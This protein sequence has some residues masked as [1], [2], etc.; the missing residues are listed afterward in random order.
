MEA[1]FRRI[2]DSPGKRARRLDGRCENYTLG[3]CGWERGGPVC[4]CRGHVR[5]AVMEREIEL[6]WGA[7]CY[8]R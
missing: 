3:N 1:S 2:G 7:R 4:W 5:E 8:A 6:D